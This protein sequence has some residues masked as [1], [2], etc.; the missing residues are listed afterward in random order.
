[1]KKRM[2]KRKFGQLQF[3]QLRMKNEHL[4]DRVMSYPIN[5]RRRKQANRK[6]DG[7][8]RKESQ[9]GENRQV[10]QTEGLEAPPLVSMK[11]ENNACVPHFRFDRLPLVNGAPS[12]FRYARIQPRDEWIF[13]AHHAPKKTSSWH[14]P[15]LFLGH[16]GYEPGKIAEHP[17]VGG[18]EPT[19]GV[20]RLCDLKR[21]G[22]IGT[23]F[24]RR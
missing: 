4:G 8:G 10:T 2:M 15:P 13:S 7:C 11:R 23:T 17:L 22:K 24:F 3:E 12:K 9:E 14:V 6:Q 1:M 20:E 18:R 16:L 19:R 21:A 5:N